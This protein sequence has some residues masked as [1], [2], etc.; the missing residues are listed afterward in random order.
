MAEL[1]NATHSEHTTETVIAPAG[2]SQEVTDVEMQ[3][4]D[5]EE[6][7]NLDPA[8]SLQTSSKTGGVEEEE[9]GIA[10]HLGATG[11]R[12]GSGQTE[13]HQGRGGDGQR[14]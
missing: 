3:P 7:M 11:W 4:A 1:E 14:E 5:S 6:G 12:G 2:P 10:G 8:F 13:G 9:E